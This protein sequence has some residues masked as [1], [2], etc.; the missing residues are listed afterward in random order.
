MCTLGSLL[1]TN[2]FNYQ[3]QLINDAITPTSIL[4]GDFNLD[5]LRKFDF[6]YPYK[7]YFEDKDL[8]L[9]NHG[10]NQVVNCPPFGS[11][12]VRCK[13]LFL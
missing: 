7:N 2:K 1:L 11:Y 12:K 8:V 9:G 6:N 3:S 13:K 5:W 10:L 4:L